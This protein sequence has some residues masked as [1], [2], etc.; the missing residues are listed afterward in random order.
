MNW[1]NAYW[2]AMSN[3]FWT[4]DY[5]GLKK[6]E[7]EKAQGYPDRFMVRKA[8]IPSGLI[9]TRCRKAATMP[10]H[11]GSRE[12]TLNHIV[13]IALAMA[14][15]AL[16]SRLIAEPLDIQDAGGFDYI[17]REVRERHELTGGPCQPDGFLVSKRSAIALELKL[18]SSAQPVQ[19]VKYAYMLAAEE[20]T[21]GT[22]DHLGLLYFVPKGHETRVRASLALDDRPLG[23]DYLRWVQSG[24]LSKEFRQLLNEHADATS[25]ILARLR[26]CVQ[27]WTWF[28][29]QIEAVELELDETN[30]AQQCYRRML[31]GLRNQIERHGRTGVTPSQPRSR[32]VEALELVA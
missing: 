17:G 14:P 20:R 19:L 7:V 6:V 12:E 13:D 29:D 1:N 23:P 15:D 3:I 25:E 4:L 5:V 24:K 26:I 31:G 32:P 9:Y 8:D 10:D 21:H 2:N 30:P 11:L 27:N 16:I 28:R 18:L 22:K